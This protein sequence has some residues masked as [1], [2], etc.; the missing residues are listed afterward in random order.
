[1]RSLEGLRAR[2]SRWIAVVVWALVI[3]G[4]SSMPGSAI[5]GSVADYSPVAHFTEYAVLAVLVVWATGRRRIGIGLALAVL[6]ACSLYGAS[7]E[8]HQSFTPGRTPDVVDWAT[9][10]L[11]AGT[12]LATVMLITRRA[13]TA[14]GSGIRNS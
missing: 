10:T 7:D 2:R 14:D 6:L 1:M 11:G 13:R 9:D 3:F 5:P 4:L 12:A 8:F